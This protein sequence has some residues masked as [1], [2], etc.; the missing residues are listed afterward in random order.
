MTLEETIDFIHKASYKILN[1]FELK[2]GTWQANLHDGE[3]VW[4]F[5][6]SD[7]PVKALMTALSK[8]E[9]SPGS[10]YH[11]PSKWVPTTILDDL[12]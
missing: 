5:G 2:D 1:L 11:K 10:P 6:R 9:S 8:A 12:F 4:E 7:T 3:K